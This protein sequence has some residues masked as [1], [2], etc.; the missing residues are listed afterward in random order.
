MRFLCPIQII[1]K[2]KNVYK[3]ISIDKISTP[4]LFLLKSL[5]L[6]Q[7]FTQSFLRILSSWIQ[8]VL[9][10]PKKGLLLGSKRSALTFKPTEICHCRC[11]LSLDNIYLRRILI[12]ENEGHTETEADRQTLSRHPPTTLFHWSFPPSELINT[13]SCL[14]WFEG[15]S[16]RLLSH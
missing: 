11:W 16:L 6:N 8:D 12:Y 10:G 9:I 3:I 4:V 7:H 15:Q 2:K 5:H 14:H 1:S 13:L